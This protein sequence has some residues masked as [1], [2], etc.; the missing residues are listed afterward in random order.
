MEEIGTRIWARFLIKTCVLI[1]DSF[2]QLVAQMIH[3]PKLVSTIGRR[4]QATR[5]G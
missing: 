3:L 1:V 2:F 5:V 4:P